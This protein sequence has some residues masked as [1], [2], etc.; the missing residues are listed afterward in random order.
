MLISLINSNNFSVV[1]EVFCVDNHIIMSFQFLSFLH[2]GSD[3]TSC[4]GIVDAPPFSFIESRIRS[5]VLCPAK[6]TEPTISLQLG[7]DRCIGNSFGQWNLGLSL[8][9]GSPFPNKRPNFVRR[10]LLG[11]LLSIPVAQTQDGIGQ[12]LLCVHI[13]S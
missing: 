11:L 10:K 13:S 4:L 2:L 6:N 5:S 12:R 9:K 8:W 7:E 3:N 1:F